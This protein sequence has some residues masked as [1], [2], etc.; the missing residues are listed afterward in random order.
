MSRFSSSLAIDIGT[1]RSR[2]WSDSKG[3]LGSIPSMVL[4]SRTR[5]KPIMV[6]LDLGEEA[7]PDYKCLSALKE[8]KAS[9]LTGIQIVCR[10]LLEKTH[11]PLQKF[12]PPT[13]Y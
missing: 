2:A 10:A 5:R 6:T 7:P 11:D 12:L 8:G 9:S 4:I 1:S 13:V 3:Y